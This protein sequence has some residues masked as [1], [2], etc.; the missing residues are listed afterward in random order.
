MKEYKLQKD[1]TTAK[2]KANKFSF[3]ELNNSS[4][5]HKSKSPAKSLNPYNTKTPLDNI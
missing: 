1:L 3:K 2:L 5:T 4:E